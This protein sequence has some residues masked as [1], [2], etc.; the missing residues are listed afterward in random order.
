M[1]ERVSRHWGAWWIPI[2]LDFT[3]CY[4]SFCYRAQINSDCRA[5]VLHLKLMQLV[6]QVLPLAPCLL[7]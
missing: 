5:T 7:S 6:L 1:N 2:S 3:S 4:A